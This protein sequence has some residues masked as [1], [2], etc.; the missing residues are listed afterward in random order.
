MDDLFTLQDF[1]SSELGNETSFI[2]RLTTITVMLVKMTIRSL[3]RFYLQK[4]GIKD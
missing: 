1:V 2:I 4:L 3:E